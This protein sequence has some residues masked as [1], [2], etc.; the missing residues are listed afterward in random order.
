MTE[1]SENAPLD[2]G[3][4]FLFAAPS[5]SS[6]NT[7]A[8][9]T[10]REE[11]QLSDQGDEE[12]KEEEE[13]EVRIP[14]S[15]L[16]VSDADPGSDS[17]S[18]KKVKLFNQ[19]VI[20][21]RERSKSTARA[22]SY[23][24][25]ETYSLLDMD[26]LRSKAELRIKIKENNAQLK[27]ETNIVNLETAPQMWTDKYRPN[28][29]L[30]L[31]S[32]GNDKQYRLVMKWLS[33]WSAVV[34][35]ENSKPEGVDTLGRPLRKILLIHGPPGIGKTVAAH[36]LARQMGYDLQ[37]LNAANSMDTLPH[38]Q[39]GGGSSSNSAYA[40]A[41]N[42]LKLKITNSLTSNSVS[43]NTKP[44]CL[45]ID[46]LD[47]MANVGDIVRVLTDII[48]SD[49]RAY[50]KRK[51][52]DPKESKSTKNK[53]KD[54][55]LNRP[56][57]CI[58]N[59]IYSRQ[60]GRVGPN[61]LEKIRAMAEVVNFRKPTSAQRATG[62]KISS[63]SMKS[64]KDFLM[65]IN[66]N[67]KLGLDYREVGDICENCEAD[68][69]ACLNQMQFSG[70]RLEPGLND[71]PKS[72]PALHDKNVSWFSMVDEIFRRD[73][74]L[75]KEDNFIKLLDKYMNGNGKA[76][77]G[78]SDSFDKLMNGIFGRYLDVV[79][80]QDNSLSRPAEFSDWM[81]HFDV[82]LH[83]TH[84]DS[85]Q[86]APLLALK[87]WSLFSD[88]KVHK[89]GGDTNTL[90]P[91]AKNLAY[92]SFEALKE[93]K[94]VVKTVMQNLPVSTLLALGGG[95]NVEH[96]ATMFLP[97]A[98]KILSP[99]FTSKIKSNLAAHELVWL[100]K[101][102]QLS[103]DL[104]LG[105]EFQREVETGQ[106]QLKFSPDWDGLSL[107]ESELAKTPAAIDKK[108]TQLKRQ[109]LFPLVTAELDNR[110]TSTKKR[111][112]DEIETGTGTEH[113]SKYKKAK[114]DDGN[115]AAVK[116]NQNSYFFKERYDDDGSKAAAAADGEPHT[117]KEKKGA[118]QRI[119]VNY[120]EGFS[121]AVRKKVSWKDIW[122]P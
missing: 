6:Q 16:R 76:V 118:T 74:Q 117:T 1:M 104:Q 2:L 71:V 21:L 113:K 110:S 34:F 90:V 100:D 46:E 93:H 38:A 28:N 57:I 86:Y 12:A 60:P 95:G 109:N 115:D 26:S 89:I 51:Y 3:A 59:D 45:L 55:M 8:G 119:W 40:N 102:T 116:K 82:L 5:L 11:N 52:S 7:Q 23:N 10:F 87:S 101:V 19:Q 81:N 44:T 48:N 70:R 13:P 42:A 84:M 24:D 85:S 54:K 61:P 66:E 35:G 62:A 65:T 9:V 20:P 39:L 49:Q 18:C 56:I 37:E 4:S 32:A 80:L 47:S 106:T 64:V 43:N 108:Q 79:H 14:S 92:E 68:I 122:L 72:N 105:F 75:K 73:P 25:V 17:V 30:Q 29:F 33:K 94:H 112:S 77:T 63:N 83:H 36:I 88:I 22:R 53:K 27:R 107:Y 97:F 69:R 120:N 50:N 121:N 67:E 99:A 31:C 114:V 58:A 96:C 15:P 111:H 103:S 41:A 91:N 78:S 98:S